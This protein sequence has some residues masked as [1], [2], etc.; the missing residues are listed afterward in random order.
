[1]QRYRLA[2]FAALAALPLGARAATTES[3][4]QIPTAADLAALCGAQPDDRLYTAAQN[5]CE[6][7]AL[8]VYNVLAKEEAAGGL[9]TFCLPDPAPTRDQLKSEFVAFIGQ[10]PK[11]AGGPPEDSILQFLQTQYPCG[12]KK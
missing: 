6:G 5:F 4:F 8:G 1:M 7:F 12:G 2:V 10:S 3:Q 9:K 11:A